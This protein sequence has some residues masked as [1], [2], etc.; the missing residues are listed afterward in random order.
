MMSTTGGVEYDL[1]ELISTAGSRCS[2]FA[3]SI[4]PT[5]ARLQPTRR[6]ARAYA[7]ERQGIGARAAQLR[8]AG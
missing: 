2:I 8:N 4:S 6:R 7:G 5:H 1:R 3:R